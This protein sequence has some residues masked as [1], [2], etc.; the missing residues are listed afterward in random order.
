M[1]S[2]GLSNDQSLDEARKIMIDTVE[3]LPKEPPTKDEV[4]RVKQRLLRATE[5]SMTD[6]QMLGLGLSEWAAHGRLAPDVPQ[7]RSHCQGHSGDV[8]RVAKAYLK[9]SNRTVGEFIPTA[10]PDRAAIPA[11]PDLEALFKDYKSE[12]TVSQGESFDPTPA[13]IESRITRS[14]LA[15]GMKLA[16]LPRQTRG[17]TVEAVVELHF[18][19]A[20]SLAGKTAVAQI[21]GG[22]LMRGTRNKSRQQIQDE[23]D[24][25]NARI[26][27]SGGG[28]GMGGGR[29]R[30]TRGSGDHEFGV[31]RQCEHSDD[32][33][34]SAGGAASGRRDVA[35]TV[36]QR[37]RFRAGQAAAH[38]RLSRPIVKEPGVAG[39]RGA[40]GPHQSVPAR[41]CP[42]RGDRGG[43]DRGPQGGHARQCA[44]VPQRRSTEHR[45][46][47]WWCWVQ[48]DPEQLQQAAAE[49]LGSWNSKPRLTAASFPPTSRIAPINQK[50]DTPD[51]TNATFEAA[52]RIKMSEKDADYPAMILANQM[53]GG[54]LGSR[55]PN[56]IRNVEGLSY[57]VSSRFTAPV[58]GDAAV[59]SASA[60]SAP[61]NTAKVESS[62]VDE[63]RKTLKSG[64]TA[65][66][67]ATA[68]KAYHELTNGGAI[69][70]S[71]VGAHHSVARAVRSDHEMGRATGCQD[72]RADRGTD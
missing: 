15:N 56:R 53:F 41:R 30:R 50:I 60:I 9:E 47:K 4:E 33:R 17:G 67:V 66:E 16:M 44:Q 59:F 72:R 63:L 10:Q 32:C 1:V 65:E 6:S 38:R 36:V 26:M 19:D 64:F 8:V 20:Q 49:L 12:L 55:M 2:A 3:G 34:E 70:G 21:A 48:F 23:M 13:N 7:S 42:S 27:V 29:S 25:L 35:R 14:K 45:M 58:E 37:I 28:G 40:A 31:E 57:S 39:D 5:N 43:A 22:L 24:R 52:I 46:G 62:F 11:T 61:Q 69:A 51:K 18:G 54:S 71:R 68:K